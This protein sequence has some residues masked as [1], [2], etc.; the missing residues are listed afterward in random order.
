MKR[1]Y[2]RDYSYDSEHI[3]LL[4]LNF[5]PHKIKT[6]ML[7]ILQV[8]Y[9]W[10]YMMIISSEYTPLLIIWD[11]MEGLYQFTAKA[12]QTLKMKQNAGK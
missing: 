10:L 11:H 6:V 3:Y 1:K 4:K 7:G 2:D 9:P 5:T 12:M 8:W